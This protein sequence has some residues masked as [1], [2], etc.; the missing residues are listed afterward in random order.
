MTSHLVADPTV[1]STVLDNPAWESLVGPLSHL[2]VRVGGAARFPPDVS[3][4]AA[5][6]DLRDP[7]V[8][9]DLAEVVGPAADVVVTGPAVD[10]P[11][12]WRVVEQGEGV[13]FVATSL[14][15][16]AD[17][18]AVRLGPDDVPE[19]LALVARTQP[20]PFEPRTIELGSYL[21][22]RRRGRLVAMAG[23]RLRPPGW[24]EV[25]GVCTDARYRG[26]GLATRLVRAVGQGIRDGGREVFL[27]TAAT[28]ETAIRLYTS[29]GFT[30]RRRTT[31]ALVRT[32]G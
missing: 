28:N 4:F 9:G 18:E 22:I 3:P 29:I 32:P 19:M 17:D 25:S 26:Q 1:G 23:E 12:G 15:T 8:W 21:G 27:H 30:L 31:F 13:Q 7:E 14:R 6:R 24:V 10:A 16:A 2:A 5:V 20:G 11:A